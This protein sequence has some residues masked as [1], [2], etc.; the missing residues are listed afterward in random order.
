MDSPVVFIGVPRSQ[1]LIPVLQHTFRASREATSMV[2][3]STTPTT[4]VR[5]GL[6]NIDYSF[7]ISKN[8]K[9]NHP[10]PNLMK[11]EEIIKS[12][13]QNV[14]EVDINEIT[15]NAHLYS[16]LGADDLD[17][18]TIAQKIDEALSVD[19]NFDLFDLTVE[20]L[21]SFANSAP[22]KVSKPKTL[23]YLFAHK[24][25]PELVFTQGINLLPDLRFKNGLDYTPN[26]KMVA[27][28]DPFGE[29][30]EDGLKYLQDLWE[31]SARDLNCIYTEPDG[32]DYEVFE[33]S[34]VLM[35][36]F[37]FPEAQIPGDAFLGLF[38]WDESNSNGRNYNEIVE[39]CANYFTLELGQYN[40]NVLGE[41]LINGK[42]IKHKSYSTAVKISQLSEDVIKILQ[43]KVNN[44]VDDE[45]DAISDKLTSDSAEL[46]D[47]TEPIFKGH[48]FYK[49]ILSLA[50]KLNIPE[51][52]INRH[53]TIDFLGKKDYVEIIGNVY[54]MFNIAVDKDISYIE[55]TVEN[56]LESKDENFFN[57]NFVVSQICEHFTTAITE[58]IATQNDTRDNYQAKMALMEKS[59]EFSVLHAFSRKKFLILPW[60]TIR[61][62]LLE[63]KDL[64]FKEIL[65]IPEEQLK[66]NFPIDPAELFICFVSVAIAHQKFTQS[67]EK[68]AKYFEAAIDLNAKWGPY[69]EPTVLMD[70]K[71]NVRDTNIDDTNKSNET[72]SGC[73]IATAV[74]GTPYASEV[75]VLK[76]F[77]DNYLLRFPLG[78]A[79]V[80]CY[81]QISPPLAF[82]IAKNEYL[83]K[84][85][86]SGLIIPILKFANYLKRRG[87]KV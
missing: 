45:Y 30:I 78:R 51:S 8:K 7:Y 52:Q 53:S 50:N 83:K 63:R 62:E 77:R 71:N 64:M 5:S 46:S 17:I 29:P 18:G 28:L 39:N 2:V 32:L 31:I 24:V 16:D 37:Y 25:I 9:R 55:K 75:I 79:F 87:S 27:G 36:F 14:L 12:I 49:I 81:Y 72:K 48:I 69:I 43:Q 19:L 42:Y 86:K 67:E 23:R 21:I 11:N 44:L 60:D 6:F 40:E 22:P 3:V 20:E 80:S 56:I 57:C 76:E 33:E 34:G 58:G 15:N 65:T 74:Y 1:H 61:K 73:F 41:W 35:I 59:P 82:R 38:T 47:N 70:L 85:A 4:C 66:H 54:K 26:S 68:A 10:K 13:I 84:I